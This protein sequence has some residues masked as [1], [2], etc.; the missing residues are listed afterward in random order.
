MNDV[1]SQNI[2]GSCVLEGGQAAE[3]VASFLSDDDL[4]V[5]KVIEQAEKHG[6]DSRSPGRGNSNLPF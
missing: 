4:D 1:E 5:T 3:H 6:V 2:D